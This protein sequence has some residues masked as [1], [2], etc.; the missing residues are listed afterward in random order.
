M[1]KLLPSYG[2]PQLMARIIAVQ[3]ETAQ[4]VA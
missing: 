4:Q 1:G 3:L 2:N